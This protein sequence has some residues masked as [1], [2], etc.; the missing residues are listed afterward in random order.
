M[1]DKCQDRIRVRTLASFPVGS[2]IIELH[3]V[4][5]VQIQRYENSEYSF[6]SARSTPANKH[7]HTTTSDPATGTLRLYSAI[8]GFNGD[9][10]EPSLGFVCQPTSPPLLWISRL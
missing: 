1:G 7:T 5:K 9:T 6:L 10:F 2:L 3:R 8:E 4:M